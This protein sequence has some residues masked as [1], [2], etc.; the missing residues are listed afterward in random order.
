VIGLDALGNLVVTQINA[1][2][3]TLPGWPV[4]INTPAGF[5]TTPIQVVTDALHVGVQYT[6]LNLAGLQSVWMLFFNQAG[7]AITAETNVGDGSNAGELVLDP[8]GD[9]IYVSRKTKIGSVTP[10]RIFRASLTSGHPPISVD[11]PTN[12][13]NIILQA[14]GL[15]VVGDNKFGKYNKDFSAIL[16]GLPAA[17]PAPY[18][19]GG[20]CFSSTLY[21]V[22]VSNA[23]LNFAAYD[24]IGA[25]LYSKESIVPTL[26][27]KAIIRSDAAGN[28]YFT[29]RGK[30]GKVDKLTGAVITTNPPTVPTG[31]WTIIGTKAY[32]SLGATIQAYDLTTL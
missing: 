21:T 1:V 29:I 19:F 9:T 31:D 18:I 17:N 2:G 6:R 30:L 20:T 27:D 24:S 26:T 16:W 14:Y 7:I 23:H 10:S 28:V 3:A 11:P 5:T 15:C 22:G 13:M 4:T 12:P 25:S 8:D 32:F